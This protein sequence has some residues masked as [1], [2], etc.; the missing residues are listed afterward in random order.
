MYFVPSWLGLLQSLNIKVSIE[1]REREEEED[2]T[3]CEVFPRQPVRGVFALRREQGAEL[4]DEEHG[5]SLVNGRGGLHW[6]QHCI[7]YWL[8]DS[9]LCF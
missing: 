1:E 9:L 6:Q 2:G 8:P 5:D 4:R 3:V 7:L